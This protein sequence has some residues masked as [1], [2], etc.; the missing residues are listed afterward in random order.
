VRA[1]LACRGFVTSRRL[2]ALTFLSAL[3]LQPWKILAFYNWLKKPIAVNA[4]N[5]A[6]ALLLLL[7]FCLVLAW[8]MISVLQS[9]THKTAYDEPAFREPGPIFHDHNAGQLG[10]RSQFA[11]QS[12]SHSKA[13]D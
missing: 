2:G 12:R 13:P 5:I 4:M 10:A 9:L 8:A 7:C 3:F 1:S 11:W 6:I